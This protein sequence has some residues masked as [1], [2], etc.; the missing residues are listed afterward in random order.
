MQL[1]DISVHHVRRNFLVGDSLKLKSAFRMAFTSFKI[2]H[3]PIKCSVSK[4][5]NDEETKI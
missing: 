4:R 5:G 3:L 2:L 1:F